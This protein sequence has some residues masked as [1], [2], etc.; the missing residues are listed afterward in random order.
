MHQVKPRPP[1]PSTAFTLPAKF[2]ADAA[3]FAREEETFFS[4][5]WMSVGRLEDIPTPGSYIVRTIAEGLGGSV[6]VTSEPDQGATFTL[7]LPRR[8]SS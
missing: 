7:F 6:T 3:L 2:Y 1:L 8:S 5:M 4:G